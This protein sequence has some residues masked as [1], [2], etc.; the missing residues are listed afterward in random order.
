MNRFEQALGFI[1]AIILCG[2][3]AAVGPEQTDAKRLA[4][5]IV[6]TDRAISPSAESDLF[7]RILVAEVAGKRGKLDLA[8]ENYRLAAQSSN[9]PSV[10]RARCGHR[11]VY[12]KSPC[13]FRNSATLV[14]VIP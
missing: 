14:R 9:D 12:G 4:Q 10:G 3:A 5:V 7:Y 8:L 1:I 11:S 13:R 2:S 6:R